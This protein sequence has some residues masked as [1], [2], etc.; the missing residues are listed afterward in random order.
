[1][2]RKWVGS[3]LLIWDQSLAFLSICSDSLRQ[4]SIFF[5]ISISSFR[6]IKRIGDGIDSGGSVLESGGDD[7]YNVL[8]HLRESGQELSE[9]TIQGWIHEPRE[10]SLLPLQMGRWKAPETRYLLLLL[11]SLLSSGSL[12]KCSFL[13]DRDLA[14]CFCVILSVSRW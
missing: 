9:R 7:V 5:F 12:T 1:M 4:L 13:F 14:S 3:W 11:H 10:G 6:S 8:K 2:G